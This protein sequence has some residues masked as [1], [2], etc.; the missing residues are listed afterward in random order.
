MFLELRVPV[1]QRT[2]SIFL[3]PEC[4]DEALFTACAPVSATWTQGPPTALT[5]NCGITPSPTSRVQRPLWDSLWAPP[6]Q[7]SC[8]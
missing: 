4:Q 2:I 8:S 7:C 6:I 3:V 1:P 5:P